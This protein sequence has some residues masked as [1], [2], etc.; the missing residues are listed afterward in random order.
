MN[1]KDIYYLI[2]E[3][4]MQQWKRGCNGFKIAR[5]GTFYYIGDLHIEHENDYLIFYST[6]EK[7]LWMFVKDLI[8]NYEYEIINGLIKCE[9]NIN[10]EKILIEAY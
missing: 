3:I 8:L 1:T 4:E 10:N 2:D 9:I 5:S 6:D 7:I